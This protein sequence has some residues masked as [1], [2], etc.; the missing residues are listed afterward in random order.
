MS[1][2]I[3]PE[4]TWNRYP[5]IDNDSLW[6]PAEEYSLEDANNVK[7]KSQTILKTSQEFY[8]WWFKEEQK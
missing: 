3:E 8:R 4:V 5:G 6:I 1:T 2:E 7:E